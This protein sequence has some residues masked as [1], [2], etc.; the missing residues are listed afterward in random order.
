MSS[1]NPLTN[2]TLIKGAS[3]F[4]FAV[5]MDKFVLGNTDLN[6]SLMFAGATTAGIVVGEM[7]AVKAITSGLLPDSA[8][9]YQGKLVSQRLLELT[10]GIGSGYALN[11]FVLK[12]DYNRNDFLKR[13]GVIAAVDVLAEY[14]KDYILGNTI[15]YLVE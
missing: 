4:A 10:V 15:G 3:S 2:P 14:A 1:S 13:L 12:N 11:S 5:A 8:G 7:I 6:Q 9:L